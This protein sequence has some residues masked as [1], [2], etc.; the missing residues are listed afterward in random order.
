MAKKKINVVKLDSTH[1]SISANLEEQSM[2]L[3]RAAGVLYLIAE[4]TCGEM[5]ADAGNA[6]W[7]AIDIVNA[8]RDELDRLGSEHMKLHRQI[9]NI[10]EPTYE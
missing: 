5:H 9:N 8:V 6:L 10:P 1:W 2:R 3:D 4:S 7:A